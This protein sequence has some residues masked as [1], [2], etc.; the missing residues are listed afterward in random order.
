MKKVKVLIIVLTLILASSFLSKETNAQD[1]WEKSQL[2]A[3]HPV[4]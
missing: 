1:K 3:R 4:N 2:S